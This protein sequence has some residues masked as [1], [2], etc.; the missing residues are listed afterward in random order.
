MSEHL[1]DAP[2]TQDI[3]QTDLRS[4]FRTAIH[5]T[6]A[7]MLEAEIQQLVGAS[8]GAR[9]KARRDVR[10]GSYPR[11]FLTSEGV[12]DLVVPRTGEHGAATATLGRYKRRVEAIDDTVVA[13]YVSGVSTRTMTHV[14]ETLLGTA[15]DKST[16]SRSTARLA[17]TIEAL[18]T[19]PIVDEMVYLYLDPT[20]VKT[21]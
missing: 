14:T 2:L 16:V 9:T 15:V 19:A 8:S 4:M 10:N 1:N 6:L 5:Q 20:F 12:I 7:V 17:A 3:I 21:R 18:R 11:Q 13:A